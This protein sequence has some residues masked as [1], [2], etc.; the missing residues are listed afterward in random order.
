ML[1][2]LCLT[3]SFFQ[4]QMKCPLIIHP[5]RAEEAPYEIIDVLREAGADI[6]KTVMSHLDRTLNSKESCL[7]VSN[8]S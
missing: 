1:N 3:N 4:A 8:K 6:S 5:G 2:L 7:K